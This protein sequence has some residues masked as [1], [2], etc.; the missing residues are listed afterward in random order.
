M[1]KTSDTTL[2]TSG[3]N[4]RFL[5]VV[6]SYA[7]GLMYVSMLLQRFEYNIGAAKKGRKKLN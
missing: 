5:L 2:N 7:N 3:R 6:D 4:S 1:T